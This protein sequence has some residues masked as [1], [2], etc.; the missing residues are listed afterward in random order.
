[1]MV[2][3]SDGTQT[4]ELRETFMRTLALDVLITLDRL[5]K[6]D[7]QA[8]RR[9]F[10]RA[11]FAAVEGMVWQFR[12]EIRSS[13][14]ELTELP[15]M[16]AMAMTEMSYSVSENGKL[17]D[18]QRF[19]PLPTMIRLVTNVAKELAPSL[20]TPFDKTGWADLKRTIVIRNRITHPKGISDLHVSLEDT[21]VG[22]SGLIWLLEHIEYVMKA[23]CAA[24]VE[25]LDQLKVLVGELKAGDPAALESYRKTF[26]AL[27]D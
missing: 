2:D 22:W 19:I 27:N 21:K 6:D 13:A 12:E 7:K 3:K 17:I 20:H 15:P 23:V 1:M 11:L 26:E 18:Q 5:E 24:Q 4:E 8:S 9:D 10:I 25:Y 14:E 16:M